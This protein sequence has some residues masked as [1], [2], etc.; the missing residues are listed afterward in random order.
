LLNLEYQRRLLNRLET[1]EQD[2]AALAES[3]L[4]EIQAKQ[5]QLLL[6]AVSVLLLKVMNATCIA[7]YHYILNYWP[8]KLKTTSMKMWKNQPGIFHLAGT[9]P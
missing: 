4:Q 5:K 6:T 3:N 9:Q 2:F 7:A 1:K 8:C